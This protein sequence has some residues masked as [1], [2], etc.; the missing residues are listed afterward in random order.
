MDSGVQKIL[1]DRMKVVNYYKGQ[2][3]KWDSSDGQQV[4]ER[5]QENLSKAEKA[6][7][8]AV[9]KYSGF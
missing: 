3:N 1:D 9:V 8:N 6:Y 2:L 4:K 7:E 5:I